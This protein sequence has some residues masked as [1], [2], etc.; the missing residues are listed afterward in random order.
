MWLFS[1]LFILIMLLLG[2]T[3]VVSTARED[4]RLALTLSGLL[5]GLGFWTAAYSYRMSNIHIAGF[6]G[7]GN[8]LSG[9]GAGIVAIVAVVGGLTLIARVLRSSARR[10]APLAF[11]PIVAM[12]V[13]DAA[14]SLPRHPQEPRDQH[15]DAAYLLRA[16][17]MNYLDHHRIEIGSRE[18]CILAPEEY[19]ETC[20]KTTWP[21]PLPVIRTPDGK[22][23]V[24]T[25]KS[26]DRE[27]GVTWARD[28]HK[29][30][31]L[32]C[33]LVWAGIDEFRDE[34]QRGCEDYVSGR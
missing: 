12:A 33:F 10:F 4:P 1:V 18:E 32:D 27:F 8:E 21:A 24:A 15:L 23:D 30:R 25:T 11:L 34:V 26:K 6:E 29:T 3:G 16:K 2:I 28:K 7:L 19:W 5:F 20:R 31:K 22:V 14:P 13:L 9:L 17:S